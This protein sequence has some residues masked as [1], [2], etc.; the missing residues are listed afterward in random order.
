MAGYSRLT[1]YKVQHARQPTVQVG[2]TSSGTPVLLDRRFVE[3]LATRGCQCGPAPT[4]RG[5]LCRSVP[6]AT[7]SMQHA[8]VHYA[9]CNMHSFSVLT[10]P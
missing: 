2:T 3:V 7:C 6:H 1:A 4:R 5:A 10:E 9:A 8:R